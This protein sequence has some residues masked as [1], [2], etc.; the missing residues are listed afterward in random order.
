MHTIITATKSEKK[1]CEQEIQRFISQNIHMA[2][3]TSFLFFCG[4]IIKSFLNESISQCAC[5][6]DVYLCPFM[7]WRLIDF[8]LL[9]II[10]WTL[11]IIRNLHWKLTNVRNIFEWNMNGWILPCLHT[12]NVIDVLLLCILCQALP[13]KLEF[14]DLTFVCRLVVFC[15][16]FYWC[17]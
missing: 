1:I 13:S 12:H 9:Y 4:V 17:C 16:T 11:F 8:F 6:K 15:T 5:I 7:R 14:R 10:Q 3:L 2:W